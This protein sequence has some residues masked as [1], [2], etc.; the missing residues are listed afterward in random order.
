MKKRMG[1]VLSCFL[2]LFSI[3]PV[4]AA[5]F[6]M[7]IFENQN[8]EYS[9]YFD[10]S[11]EEPY[12]FISPLLT[13]EEKSFT[14]KY[15]SEYYYSTISPD[16]IVIDYQDVNEYVVPRIWIDYRSEGKN[17]NANVIEFVIG[18]NLYS[19]SPDPPTVREIGTVSTEEKYILMLGESSLSFISDWCDAAMN[20]IAVSA[21][22]IGGSNTIYFDVPKTVVIDAAITFIAYVEAGGMDSMSQIYETPI[23]NS[24]ISSLSQTQGGL[25]G[26]LEYVLDH[27]SIRLPRNYNVWTVNNYRDGY[28]EDWA[29]G[30]FE[31][32]P[33]ACLYATNYDDLFIKISVDIDVHD[34]LRTM[35]KP[36]SELIDE[37]TYI[38]YSDAKKIP[39]EEKIQVF[40]TETTNFVGYSY[41]SNGH[42]RY[43]LKYLWAHNGHNYYMSIDVSRIDEKDVSQHDL[44]TVVGFL[45]SLNTL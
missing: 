29:A 30:L 16:L 4:L 12:V 14:H 27:F 15:E 37:Y 1:F 41:S 43:M 32:D 6:D 42:I 3:S 22:L 20:D 28:Y 34:M 7:S 38:M 36:D 23:Q 10:C 33:G 40:K 11:Y 13:I 19:F 5:S 9:K 26:N 24:T 35:G 31:D 39:K 44:D 17:I 45:E 18:N 21:K 2:I 25:N 8:S